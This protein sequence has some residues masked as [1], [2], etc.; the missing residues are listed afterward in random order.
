MDSVPLN[1][2]WIDIVTQLESGDKNISSF[3]FKYKAMNHPRVAEDRIRADELIAWL[4]QQDF[5]KAYK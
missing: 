2:A 3:V 5:M 1:K 4:K